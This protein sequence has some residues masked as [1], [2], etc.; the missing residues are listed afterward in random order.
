MRA[1][2]TIQ[3][4]TLT[5]A[6]EEPP[7]KSSTEDDKPPSTRFQEN[8]KQ[9]FGH[10]LEKDWN[11]WRWQFQNRV[12][13]VEELARLIPLSTEEQVRLK[14]VTAEYPLSITPYYFCLTDRHNPN[15]PIR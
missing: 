3:E 4:K 7:G 2:P 14:L 10:V 9:F 8:R 5:A 11:D 12:A 13:S 1:S 6:D 15:D